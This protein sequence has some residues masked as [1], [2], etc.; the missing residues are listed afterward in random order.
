MW[1]ATEVARS[2]SGSWWDIILLFHMW[3]SS[4]KAGGILGK[5]QTRL[6]VPAEERDTVWGGD[7]PCLWQPYTSSPWLRGGQ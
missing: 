2:I 4:G 5:G 6:G 3:S 7:S 1:S